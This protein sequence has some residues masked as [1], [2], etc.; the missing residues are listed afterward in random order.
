VSFVEEE[1]EVV[2][3]PASGSLR[4]SSASSCNATTSLRKQLSLR[5][6]QILKGITPFSTWVKPR[7]RLDLTLALLL[8]LYIEGRTHLPSPLAGKATREEGRGAGRRR[9]LSRRG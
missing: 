9:E 2:P 1:V 4:W 8:L 6:N 3:P 7:P 5:N